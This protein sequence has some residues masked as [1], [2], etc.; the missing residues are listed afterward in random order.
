MLLLCLLMA[1]LCGFTIARAEEG[2]PLNSGK[3]NPIVKHVLKNGLTILIKPSAAN[4]VVTVDAFVRMGAR[5]ETKDSRGISALMQRVL[6]KGTTTRGA[7][8][9][10]FAT[11]SVGSTIDAKIADYH[12]GRVSLRSTLSGIQPGID[13][14]LDVLSHP[15]FP[16]NEVAKER[17]MLIQ[18]LSADGDQPTSFAY[19]N[20]LMLFYEDNSIGVSPETMIENLK[21]MTKADLERWYRMV[22]VPKNMVIS[23]VGNVNPEWIISKI[24][25]VWGKIPEGKPISTQ[26]DGD[27]SNAEDRQVI[28]KRES[29]ALFMILGYP[30]PT[31]GDTDY[32]TM[33]VIS[34][35][36][37]GDMGSRLFVDL[38][39]QKG[40]AYTVNTIYNAGN[41][42]SHILAFMATKPTNYQLAKEG[43]IA[44]FKKIACEPVGPVELSEA[45]Q[46]I[47][48]RFMMVHETN[49]NQSALLGS[50]ELNGLGY[51]YDE[52]YP[53]LV[54]KV[55]ADDIQRVAKAYFKHYTMSVVS[56][57]DLKD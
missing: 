15:S 37:G 40:L 24:E 23:V 52:T 47:R 53:E 43:L 1:F 35:I 56:P 2:V 28:K 38:R 16:E 9:I 6:T 17:E 26:R 44:E 45:K 32:P 31:M 11:E 36:L 5:Y 57:V 41:Y 33:E 50:F 22:Y 21:H 42:P 14:F 39:D 10:A 20:F 18:E 3:Q 13:L 54:E 25:E 8:E 19:R 30:A 4:Q 7:R 46:A 49:A 27:R 55:T 34:Y 29:Q 12:Y 48:G 51:R